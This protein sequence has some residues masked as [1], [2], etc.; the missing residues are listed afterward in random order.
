MR[1][2]EFPKCG[3]ALWVYPGIPAGVCDNPAYGARLPRGGN[4]YPPND[5]RCAEHGGPRATEMA[6]RG[7]PCMY[8]DTPHDKVEPGMCPDRVRRERRGA[9]NYEP[10]W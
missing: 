8:C 5:F 3:T 4:R 1:M 2:S 9:V 10:L 6:H 7:D